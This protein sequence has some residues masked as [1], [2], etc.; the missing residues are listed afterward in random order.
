MGEFT[1][2]GIDQLADVTG[3]AM[4]METE[5]GPGQAIPPYPVQNQNGI[6][7]PRTDDS[8]MGVRG[9]MPLIGP[10][11]DPGRANRQIGV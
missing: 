9:N 8:A 5:A 10:D 7:R 3:G 4:G 2:I 11:F 6:L 1:A